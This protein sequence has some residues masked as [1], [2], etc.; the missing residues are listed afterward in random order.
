[1]K[2]LLVF[3]VACLSTSAVFGQSDNGNSSNF[4]E[5]D[6]SWH[7]C[8]EFTWFGPDYDNITRYNNTCSDYLDETR[9]D[10]V[11][12]APPIVISYDGTPPDMDYLWDNYKSSILC[13]RSKNQVCVKY[14]Y[15]FNNQV[16]NVT[17][18]CAK[19]LSLN[20]NTAMSSGCYRQSLG[21]YD[22]EV[23]ICKSGPGI[24]RPCNRAIASKLSWSL[25][26]LCILYY[27]YRNAF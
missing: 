13:K 18:M 25:I 6:P 21:A 7:Y 20:S 3:L 12:C 5:L 8:Y 17:Y 4:P 2:I 26:L 9:A 10:G 22:T 15:Y 23:C 16:N 11:P 14:T 27:V 1:M 24:Y 19:V